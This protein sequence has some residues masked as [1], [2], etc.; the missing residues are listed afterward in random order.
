MISRQFAQ[1]VWRAIATGFV[2]WASASCSSSTSR[3][4]AVVTMSDGK[5]CFS[6]AKDR[7]TKDGIPMR[8]IT[9]NEM[10][11][12]EDIVQ[13]QRWKMHI[14]S[15]NEF[16]ISPKSCVRHGETPPGGKQ[17]LDVPLKPYTTYFVL[18]DAQPRNPSSRVDGYGAV[19]CMQPNATGQL[20]LI[21][22]SR[23]KEKGQPFELC[24]KPG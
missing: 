11:T 6:V 22:A 17:H 15:A 2:A 4:E 13:S 23:S 1:P 20:E 7:D 14:E 24:K 21:T 9:V 3:P 18:I 12:D 10:N 5:P 19:F 16:V 8:A